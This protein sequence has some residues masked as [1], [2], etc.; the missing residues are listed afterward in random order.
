MQE[1]ALIPFALYDISHKH[2]SQ[3]ITEVRN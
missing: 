2:G 3:T 1:G